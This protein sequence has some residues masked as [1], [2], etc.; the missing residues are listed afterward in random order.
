LGG[1]TFEKKQEGILMPNVLRDG[2]AG[3]AAT[4]STRLKK[5]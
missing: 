2:I 3:S 4:P 5:S 1:Y